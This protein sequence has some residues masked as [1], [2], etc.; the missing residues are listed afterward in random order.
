MRNF[1]AEIIDVAVNGRHAPGTA[2]KTPKTGVDWPELI[3]HGKS[4]V[5]I[6][7]KTYRVTVEQVKLTT[8]AT[9]H[10]D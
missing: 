1:I 5:L 9:P 4:H 7:G 6:Q 8:K 10:A 3:R 2:T